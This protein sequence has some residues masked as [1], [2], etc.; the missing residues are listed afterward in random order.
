MLANRL[1]LSRIDPNLLFLML[2]LLVRTRRSKG[3][4]LSEGLLRWTNA[5][6]HA[7]FLRVQL[8]ANLQQT[9]GWLYD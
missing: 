6:Y 8:D 5:I 4:P 3:Q 2:L 1:K 7:Y 9:V